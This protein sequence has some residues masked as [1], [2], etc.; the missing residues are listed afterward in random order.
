MVSLPPPSDL[1]TVSI[2]LL[3]PECQIVGITWY[4]AFLD[5]LLSLLLLSHFS[6]V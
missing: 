1:F 2:D 6:R 4:V 5:Q 3:F